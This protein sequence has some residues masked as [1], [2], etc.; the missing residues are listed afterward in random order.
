MSMTS[1]LFTLDELTA[2][3]SIVGRHVP[4]T[5]TY[6]WPLLTEAVGV[7]VAVK[8]E[9]MTPTGAFK[10][11]G[12]L[13]YMERLK[14]QRPGIGGVVSATRG[15]HGISL[16]FSGRVHGVRV[17]IVVP[18]GNSTEKNAA[19]RSLGAEVVIH[20]SDFEEAAGHSSA[21]A[22]EREFELVPAFHSDLVVGVATYAREL[23]A[24]AG[25]LDAVF[26]PIG[27]G[28]GICGL[29]TVR[30]LLGIPTKIIGVGADNAPAQALSFAARQVVPTPTAAT[31]V[32]GVATR[33]PN[34]TA[35]EIIRDG[36]DQVITVSD[37][38]TADAIRLLWRTSHHLAEPAG[39]IALAGLWSQR[40][41]WQDKRVA[42]V[43]CGSN[44]DTTMAAT[45]L[46]GDTPTV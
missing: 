46:S 45:V 41:Q 12:G 4:I 19:M 13:V 11:R 14:R 34:P 25:P 16:S 24:D 7:D 9:N 17:V 15:N 18:E 6:R 37:N 26:V 20:G 8:H 1:P 31:F 38:N 40:E 32:D 23:F 21:V 35:S 10:V 27:M 29:I 39:A 2:A 5:P 42:F 36:A 33:Q 28:S 3:E 30:D 22:A 44:M 43:L